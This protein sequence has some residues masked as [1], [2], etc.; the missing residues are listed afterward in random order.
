MPN[1]RR[2]YVPGGTYFFTVVTRSRRQFLTTELARGLLS[3]GIRE[4]RKVAPFEAVAIVLLPDHF[5]YIWTLPPEDVDY[6]SRIKR[7]KSSFTKNYLRS[8]GIE[9]EVSGGKRK[10]HERGVWQS[11]FWEHT[12]RDEDDFRRCLDYIHW[13]P[14]KHGYASRPCDYPYSTFHKFVR[15]GEYEPLWGTGAVVL[16]VPGAEWE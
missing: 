14:V 7:I 8:G 1:Y 5:H 3:T 11:R 9:A 2:Y 10:K 16:D 12:V 4:E 13:N 15:L 6:S